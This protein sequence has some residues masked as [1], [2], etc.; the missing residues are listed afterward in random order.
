MLSCDANLSLGFPLIIQGAT[1]VDNP[2]DD[3]ESLTTVLSV[4]KL[5]A[6]PDTVRSDVVALAH[7]INLTSAQML[8]V[9]QASCLLGQTMCGPTPSDH[10]CAGFSARDLQHAGFTARGLMRA[11]LTTRD[12]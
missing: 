3:D 2:G 10:K 11:G 12:L 9:V 7:C 6:N 4:T 8:R 1:V 5:Q